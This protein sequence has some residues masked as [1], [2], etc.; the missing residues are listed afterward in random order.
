MSVSKP[1]QAQ[2]SLRPVLGATVLF[3]LF[4][5]GLGGVKSYRDL[6]VSRQRVEDLEQSIEDAR[7][8]IELLENR[9]EQLRNDPHT[10]ERHARED[11]G[12]A[13]PGDVLILLPE[14]GEETLTAD[15]P[16]DPGPQ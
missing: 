4:L 14:D 12:L 9:I 5:L 3:L 15:S 1:P 8:R 7:Q 11:L 16:T 2:K 13:F 6:A 10:L